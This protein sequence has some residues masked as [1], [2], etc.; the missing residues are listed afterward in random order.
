M[1]GA[2]DLDPALDT[3]PKLLLDNAARHGGEVALREKQLGVWRPFTWAAVAERTE[4]FALG[5]LELGVA[6]GD[7]VGLIGDNRPDWVMGELAAHAIGALSLGI[8]RDALETEAA[9][10]IKF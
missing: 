5:L 9:Y 8:Y 4:W 10:L 1:T 2:L 7:V 3:L 6:T